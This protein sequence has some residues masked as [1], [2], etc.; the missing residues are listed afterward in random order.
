MLLTVGVLEQGL[1]GTCRQT[2]KGRI[3][4]RCPGR[5]QAAQAALA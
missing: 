3:P 4:L 2:S 5:G 1:A